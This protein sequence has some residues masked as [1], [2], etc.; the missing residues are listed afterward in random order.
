M[1]EHK[2]MSNNI[3]YSYFYCLNLSNL[4]LFFISIIP[5][6]STSQIN[7]LPLEA[8]FYPLFLHDPCIFPN[9]IYV[10]AFNYY[11]FFIKTLTM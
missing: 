3:F 1:H 9:T 2:G 4:K 11:L 6:T 7:I 10:Q 5:F 8:I